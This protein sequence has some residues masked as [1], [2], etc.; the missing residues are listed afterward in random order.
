MIYFCIFAFI[1]VVL[2]GGPKKIFV[3]LLSENVL[4]MFFSRSLKVSYL[5][6]KSLSHF[7][8]IFMPGVRVCASFID[9]HVAVQ[10]SQHHLLKR[11]SRIF[12]Q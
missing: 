5:T 12:V 1:S 8:F 7:E 2:G 6:F 4:P 10:L 9:F 11:K 3:Q